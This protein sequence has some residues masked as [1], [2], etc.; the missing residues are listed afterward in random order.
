MKTPCTYGRGVIR[1][2][3]L[4]R[5]A[6]APTVPSFPYMELANRGNT[7]ANDERSALLAAMA[8][9]AIGRYAVTRYVKVEVNT[10]YTPAPNGTE[11]M[12]GAIQCTRG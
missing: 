4:A 8:D 9:A 6:V 12:M 11:A 10:K 3:R 1:V 5:S 2:V 7:A